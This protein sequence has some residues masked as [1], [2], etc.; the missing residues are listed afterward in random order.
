MPHAHDLLITDG[1]KSIYYQYGD[2]V[3]L[4]DGVILTSNFDSE[5]INAIQ[6]LVKKTPDVSV[7]VRSVRHCEVPQLKHLLK[8]ITEH[9]SSDK[10]ELM[11]T[12]TATRA[13]QIFE[14]STQQGASDIHIELFEAQTRFEAR[15]DGRMSPLLSPI[16]EREYGELLIGYLFNELAEDKDDDFYLNRPNNGR[17]S[18]ML[19]TPEGRRVTHWRLG[20]IPAKGKGGQCTLRWTNKQTH[21]PELDTLGWSQGQ[22]RIMRDFM[23]SPSGICLIAGQTS[24]GKSTVIA[25]ALNEMKRQGRSINTLED[26]VEFDLG[27][28]QTSVPKEMGAGGFFEYSK[29]LLRHDIDIEMHG[30]VRDKNGAMSV[31]RKGETGQ[32]MFS[33]LHTSSALGIAHTLNEQMGVPTALIAAPNLMKLWIYQTLVRTLC[34]HCSQSFKKS[35]LTDSQRQQYKAWRQKRGEGQDFS[36]VRFKNPHGCEHCHQG[37]K[38]RTALIEMIVLDDEDRA[39]IL[40]RNYLGWREALRAKGFQSVVDHANH[41]IAKGEI[42]LF[43]AASSVND[44]L[45]KDSHTVYHTIWEEPNH[46][47][48]AE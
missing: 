48:T 5:A 46:E 1:L 15:I 14:L 43:T 33:T 24:S 47:K 35:T 40:D 13:R 12:E 27:V 9:A 22:T 6:S 7:E 37:E 25:S 11:Q 39:F 29:L 2:A 4:S 16:N 31:C 42:D 20:Y 45:P 30:E 41:K 18:L 21:I 8:G 10:S 3:L 36:R 28:I 44:M 38:G 32:I 23:A 34:P 17:V 19:D 26:P